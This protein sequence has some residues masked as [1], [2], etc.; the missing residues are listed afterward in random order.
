MRHLLD[1]LASSQFVH[2]SVMLIAVGFAPLYF[3]AR[4]MVAL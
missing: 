1:T 4:A 3:V 2:R